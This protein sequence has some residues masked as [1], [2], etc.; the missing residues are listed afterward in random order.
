MNN[1][2]IFYHPHQPNNIRIILDKLKSIFL[3]IKCFI[4]FKEKKKWY[5]AIRSWEMEFLEI[6]ILRC[7]TKMHKRNK[8]SDDL[9]RPFFVLILSGKVQLYLGFRGHRT[10]NIFISWKVTRISTH[11][12]R[13]HL[14]FFHDG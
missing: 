9:E 1:Q 13:F 10:W 8:I 5:Y 14:L 12:S 4:N 6:D 7:T 11:V 3:Q 2:S